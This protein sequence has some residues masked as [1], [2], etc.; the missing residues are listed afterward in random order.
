SH[1]AGSENH[2]IR[3]EIFL[4]IAV[5]CLYR[6]DPVLIQRASLRVLGAAIFLYGSS[7]H[8]YK[9]VPSLAVATLRSPFRVARFN[10]DRTF[11]LLSVNCAKGTLSATPGST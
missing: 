3:V 4:L 1:C 8:T 10:A 6:A 2:A 11:S 7:F 5:R 9:K